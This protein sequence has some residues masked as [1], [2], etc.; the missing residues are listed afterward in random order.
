MANYTLAAGTGLGLSVASST[1]TVAV[2][3]AELAAIAGLTSAA[4]KLPYFTGSGTAALADITSA[5]RSMLAAADAAAQKTLLG[6]SGTNTGDQNVFST[7]AVSGQSNVVA[8]SATDTLTL[9]AGSNITITTD[10]STDSITI[11]ASGGGGTP[12]GFNTSVQ[13]NNSSAF[14][15][16]T[17][18]TYDADGGLSLQKSV[19][20][21]GAMLP[22]FIALSEGIESG[23]NKITLSANSS[24]SSDFTLYLPAADGTNGQVLQ[25]NGSGALS[26]TSVSAGNLV[27]IATYD[28]SGNALISAAVFDNST[29]SHY[30]IIL[31]NIKPT[32]SYTD[33][34][35]YIRFA[36]SGTTVDTGSNYWTYGE[37]WSDDGSK[38]DYSLAA[39]TMI[40]LTDNRGVDHN[41]TMGYSGKISLRAGVASTSYTSIDFHGG[42]TGQSSTTVRVA[43]GTA[44][45]K[46][47]GG[48]CSAIEVNLAGFNTRLQSGKMTIYGYTRA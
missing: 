2:T 38:T 3:D 37:Y 32:A 35:V 17:K 44:I 24:M 46:A 42:W 48:G 34:D 10:A 16:D 4:N 30:D 45:H 31:E 47:S 29:Y 18:F 22:G 39:N 25:T 5:G 36:T 15:G 28:V 7:I 40:Q 14:G 12:G 13:Y 9:V 19:S 26:F 41:S 43:R 1:L 33:Y 21:G 23:S 11:A 8:D 20:I 27:R 6:V